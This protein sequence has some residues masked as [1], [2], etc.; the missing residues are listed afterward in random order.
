MENSIRVTLESTIRRVQSAIS[1]TIQ[2]SQ[3]LW[4]TLRDRCTTYHNSMFAFDDLV[5]E[6]IDS[7][8]LYLQRRFFQIK[9]SIDIVYVLLNYAFMIEQPALT[10]RVLFCFL[11]LLNISLIVWILPNVKLSNVKMVGILD[12]ALQYVLGM[13]FYNHHYYQQVISNSGTFLSLSFFFT[14]IPINL[15]LAVY[16]S[17]QNTLIVWGHAASKSSVQLYVIVALIYLMFYFLCFC[18]SQGYHILIREYSRR[19]D[20]ARIQ[21]QTEM[22]NKSMFVASVSHD[23]KNPISS[24]L[25]LID[26]LKASKSLSQEDKG[27]LVTASYSC[28]ILL[29]LIGNITDVS[30]IDAGKFD[31]DRVPMNIMEEV[32][33]VLE[34]ESELSKQKRVQLYK[35]VLTPLPG[36][37]Y[38]DP[39]RFA[40]TLI[41][42]IGNAI[43]FT[44]HG[45]VAM[46]F[47]WASNVDEAQNYE[48]MNEKDNGEGWFIPPEEFFLTRKSTM[49][50]T[51]IEE[52]DEMPEQKRRHRFTEN[53]VK[54]PKYV[55]IGVEM[56]ESVQ[57]RMTKYETIPARKQ[58]FQ[59]GSVL[60]TQPMR[61]P[62]QKRAETIS[63]A[64]STMRAHADEPP[65]PQIRS[66]DNIRTYRMLPSSS[67]FPKTEMEIGAKEDEISEDGILVTDIIDTG[68][69]MSKEEIQRLFQPF[70]Q[71]N[72]E[73][74]RQFGG[75][76]LGLW[77]TKQLISL[78]S[79]LIQ[80]SSQQK[81]GT[82]FRVIMPFKIAKDKDMSPSNSGSD[83]SKEIKLIVTL[84]VT[85]FL[86][87]RIR[88]A[89]R[90][91]Q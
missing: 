38:G 68:P 11:M 35:V 12:L 64:L 63:M 43:K 50:K 83:T 61:I 15:L 10:T 8:T 31:I 5:V 6:D 18:V 13:F 32:N 22:R 47:R 84:P 26:L 21:A 45:Y 53:P 86:E 41:N 55:D 87:Q 36:T 16:F 4:K 48:Y 37:V 89:G 19:F 91:E 76:G 7:F 49:W 74:K 34:I 71:A 70:S 59:P 28:K 1:T 42:L 23:L 80:V 72:S 29:Y 40:Q 79:G 60:V 57:E 66:G 44:S 69:G 24:I 9:H 2:K 90:D 51:I 25:G 78:M 58:G 30:K 88:R 73:V 27:A 75:T 56:D 85:Y 65:P 14:N 77:I 62:S 33:K 54:M 81:K 17:I 82:R 20:S 3:T 67:F 52:Q 39:M 46:V